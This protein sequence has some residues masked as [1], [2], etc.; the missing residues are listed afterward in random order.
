[1]LTAEEI[2]T[3]EVDFPDHDPVNPEP[4]GHD[5]D[6]ENASTAPDLD[7]VMDGPRPPPGPPP[8][9]HAP[10]DEEDGGPGSSTGTGAGTEPQAKPRATNHRKRSPHL[11]FAVLTWVLGIQ[12]PGVPTWTHPGGDEAAELTTVSPKPNQFNPTKG[13]SRRY[14]KVVDPP[15]P[16]FELPFEPV[17][18]EQSSANMCGPS[19]KRMTSALVASKWL[20]GQYPS[21]FPF[22]LQS[23]TNRYSTDQINMAMVG[24]LL[25]GALLAG[26]YRFVRTI[27]YSL[28]RL[29]MASPFC[30][31]TT[32]RQDNQSTISKH[33]QACNGKEATSGRTSTTSRTG[34]KSGHIH[35]CTRHAKLLQ[36][37]WFAVCIYP[38]QTVNVDV[39]VGG[40]SAMPPEVP[41]GTKLC[42]AREASVPKPEHSDNHRIIKRT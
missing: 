41:V 38:V 32:T 17:H 30:W 25:Y 36:L 42:G 21:P 31:T 39:R 26:C 1:M 29:R 8:G 6:S 35:S 40:P 2:R 4:T 20:S 10:A 11:F 33:I 37:I 3:I 28:P 16:L 19:G 24:P 5:P 7:Y 13:G 22:H 34:P 15:Q 12:H 23:W 18:I 14:E 27:Q 9:W